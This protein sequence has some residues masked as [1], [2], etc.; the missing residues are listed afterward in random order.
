M[1]AETEKADFAALQIL[2]VE[3]RSKPW[4]SWVMW[5]FI[6]ESNSSNISLETLGNF[7]LRW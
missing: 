7:V 5:Q 6:L 2:I 4:N 3:S 1:T